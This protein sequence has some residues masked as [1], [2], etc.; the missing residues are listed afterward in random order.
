MPAS[1]YQILIGGA[2]APEALQGALASIEVE[3]NFDLPGAILLK[4]PVSH[5]AESDLTFVNDAEL[6]P[7]SNVAV[8]A[9]VEGGEPECI[10][11][12]YVL[13]HRTKLKRGLVD[14]SL[15]V[16][17]QDS[18]W[19]MNLED[20]VR[21][22]TNITDSAVA[23][24]IFG[25]YSIGAAPEN[26]TEDSPSHVETGHTLMQRAT[27]IQFLRQLARRNGKF[28]RVVSGRAAGELSGYFAAPAL[29]ATPSVTLK[30]HDPTLPNVPALDFE[31]DV[32]RPTEM[33]ASQALFND[34]SESGV[35]GDAADSGLTALDERPLAT[36][37]GRPLKAR[38][39]TTAD[40]ASELAMRAKAVLRDA[41]FFAR[42]TG[43][44]DVAE[45]G[46]VLRAGALVSVAGAGS[47]YSGNYL[48][49]SVR[50]KIDVNSHRMSFTL[51]KNAVGPVPAGGGGIPGF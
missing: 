4:L 25:E 41:T 35:A 15:E 38:L 40:D 48:I 7:Y 32:A 34:S 26:T 23:G 9:T 33:Q 43:E 30:L 6:A 31:W 3:E 37:A 39:T 2:P 42:C 22:W 1:S 46:A 11:D 8:V 12:G 45:L 36:F 51:L 17:G 29:D 44:A 19:L 13:S 5:T 27:D 24:S 50:H 20:K 49:W 47:M 28:C 14:C 10:F 21:E 18:S 16:W